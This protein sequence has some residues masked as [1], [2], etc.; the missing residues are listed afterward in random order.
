MKY[1]ECSRIQTP[2][3]H[4]L[5]REK[6]NTEKLQDIVED[7]TFLFLAVP[8]LVMR[9]QYNLAKQLRSKNII[10]VTWMDIQ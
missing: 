8:K 6:T 7:Y 10:V 3:S 4:L 1:N 9:N 5:K 2:A